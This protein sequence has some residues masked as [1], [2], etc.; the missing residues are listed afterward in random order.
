MSSIFMCFHKTIW[1]REIYTSH[2][3]LSK[4]TTCIFIFYR[5]R[6]WNQL[7]FAKLWYE[8]YWAI[9]LLNVTGTNHMAIQTYL[10]GV[11]II[12]LFLWNLLWDLIAD[13][14][15]AFLTCI[16]F[17][18]GDR[19]TD[20]WSG[21]RAI[22]A[23]LP[24]C[25]KPM[26]NLNP[27]SVEVNLLISQQVFKTSEMIT[28]INFS[29]LIFATMLLLPRRSCKSI[30]SGY[31]LLKQTC[32][33]FLAFND[34]LHISEKGNTLERCM[35]SMLSQHQFWGGIIYQRLYKCIRRAG[36]ATR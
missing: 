30:S 26:T 35:G 13:Y 22:L 7:S 12:T 29:K 33:R 19:Q 32:E 18:R 20:M 9:N 31:L 34:L 24:S 15:L 1:N 8:N 16:G 4:N 3:L 10:T 2:S 21:L 11:P 17:F 25:I 36:S 6:H 27:F 23:A 14:V 5:W 28:S